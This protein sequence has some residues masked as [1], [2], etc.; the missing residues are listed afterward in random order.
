[1]KKLLM[2]VAV[3][4]CA[5][6]VTAQT[7]TSANIVGYTKI[8]APGSGLVFVTLGFLDEGTTS[9]SSLFG[10][11]L[12]AN[13]LVY[14]WDKSTHTYLTAAKYSRGVWNPDHDVFN[15]DGLW[16][17]SAGAVGTTNE[18]IMSGEVLTD[19]TN[20]VSFASGFVDAT[21]YYYPVSVDLLTSPIGTQLDNNSL[22]F[23]WDE[24]GQAYYGWKKSR[25][26]WTTFIP[27]S[28]SAALI[29]PADACWIQSA[30]TESIDVPRPFTP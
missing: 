9:V 7:V 24:S 10:D 13:S 2:T 22:I 28:P 23:T 6:A 27:G 25:G 12:P 11:S 16:I 15:G 30:V 4:G 14:V 1:M 19:A 3:L 8:A 18:V 20:T 29:G 17:A 5:A 21:G 26:S